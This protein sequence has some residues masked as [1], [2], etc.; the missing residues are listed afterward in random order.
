MTRPQFSSKNILIDSSGTSPTID[1]SSG[2]GYA[3]ARN[4]LLNLSE[5]FSFNETTWD[6]VRNN[7]QGT[8]IASASRVAAVVSSDQINFN[9][10][11]LILFINITVASGVGGLSFF[12][13][14]ID[15]ASGQR[16]EVNVLP[17]KIST[18]YFTVLVGPYVASAGVGTAA[19][20]MKIPRMWYV[21]V[22]AADNSAYTY[23]VGYALNE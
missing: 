7:T 14:Y 6:R 21:R 3:N 12:L 11:S 1:F 19:F 4:R 20:N 9:G 16:Y 8:L 23:S 13:G 22:A 18:G 5:I 10:D 15:P 17:N 2:D